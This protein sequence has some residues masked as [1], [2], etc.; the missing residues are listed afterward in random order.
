MQID[1]LFDEVNGEH[2]ARKDR[3][4]L[5]A[6]EV[7]RHHR[8]DLID[9]VELFRQL[10]ERQL[11]AAHRSQ[12]I[13][14]RVGIAYVY[15]VESTFGIGYSYEEASNIIL[16]GALQ[17]TPAGGNTH[18]FAQITYKK[19]AEEIVQYE[20]GLVFRKKTSSIIP[21]S[22]ILEWGIRLSTGTKYGHNMHLIQS[23]SIEGLSDHQECIERNTLSLQEAYAGSNEARQKK[24]TELES[25][26]S[27]IEETVF[28]P[29]WRPFI[30]TEDGNGVVLP[31]VISQT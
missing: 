15:P 21:S 2:E 14:D 10:S 3:Q 18:G 12:G 27:A 11:L 7:Q 28:D 30:G 4:F 26:V 9:S 29:S 25:C 5:Q 31:P 22:R 19:Q 1:A 13:L 24:I 23:T 16:L 17:H 6:D 20:K 8:E